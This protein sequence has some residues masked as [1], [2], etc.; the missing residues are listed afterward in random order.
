MTVRE[1]QVS[2]ELALGH[3]DK[4]LANKLLSVDIEHY[5]TVA[6]NRYVSN[7]VEGDNLYTLNFEERRKRIED[8]RLLITTAKG[9]S[10]EATPE[11]LTGIANSEEYNLIGGTTN[12]SF[13][14]NY[15]F[16]V[17]SLSTCSR[18]DQTGTFTIGNKLVN[19]EDINKYLT[20][21][22]NKPY[23]R[24]PVVVLL[25][26]NSM[27]LIHDA[28]TT[29]TTLDL[30][31]IRKPKRLTSNALSLSLANKE[32]IIDQ[33]DFTSFEPA[34]PKLG[35]RYLNTVGGA[36]SISSGQTFV[37]NTIVECTSLTPG[38]LWN[39]AISN[40]TGDTTIDLSQNVLYTW[41][42]SAWTKTLYSNYTH[43]NTCELPEYAHQEV[44]DI[45]VSMASST[46]EK[47]AYQF[48]DKE[49][50]K[51]SNPQAV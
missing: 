26:N 41:S 39:V 50:S 2:F 20:T 10:P 48:H 18:S 6:Q 29:I 51:N 42:G 47:E 36:G 15:L 43:S 25:E 9:I 35:D 1:M 7:R 33:R 46:Y 37:V 27:L 3:I 14:N 22:F 12:T 5:L 44:V 16:Y 49:E 24:E 38:S 30:I 19:Y 8:L 13:I 32:P 4:V 40:T 23:L 21:P 45:A 11:M 28:E 31:Y 17:N 34:N